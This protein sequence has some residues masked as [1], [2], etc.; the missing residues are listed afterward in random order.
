[1]E[2][3]SWVSGMASFRFSMDPGDSFRLYLDAVQEAAQEIEE[4]ALVPA[5]DG[6]KSIGG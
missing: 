4:T 5:P 3:P 2:Q 6:L 1:M